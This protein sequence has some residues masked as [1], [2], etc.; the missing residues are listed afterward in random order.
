[1]PVGRCLDPRAERLGE[2]LLGREAL[3]EIGGRQTMAAEALQ[4]R[5][6]QDAACEAL[7]EPGKR[8]L[9]ATD[10]HYV[11]TDTVD[12]RAAWS[13]SAFISRTAS[14]MPTNTARDTMAWPICS[15]RTPGSRA[16]GPTLK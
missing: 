13:M 10:L 11:G 15:S 9:D 6:A 12:H 16:T 14:R 8:L 1:M 3:R 5:L 4:F 2:G 7:A